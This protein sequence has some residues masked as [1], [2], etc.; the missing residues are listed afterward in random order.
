MDKEKYYKYMFLVSACYNILNSLI[1]IIISIGKDAAI[2]AAFGVLL[3]NSMVWL[4]LSLLLILILGLGYIIVA[5]DLSQN[6]GLV[7]I[8]GISKVVFCIIT[9]IY[10]ALGEV[11]IMV[12]LLG[13]VDI[14]FVCLFV[15]FL[16]K[17]NK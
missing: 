5:M 9:I 2:F 11:G 12:V 1:F 15:E 8:G 17:Y 16:L 10:L 13:G 6:H 7:I 14:I 3:P 4:Q